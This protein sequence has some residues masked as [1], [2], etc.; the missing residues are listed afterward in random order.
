MI[1]KTKY[2]TEINTDEIGEGFG[3]F[4]K[5]MRENIDKEWGMDKQREFTKT[6]KYKV[7]LSATATVYTTEYIEAENKQ[8]AT[9]IA[10]KEAKN[11]NWIILDEATDLD[12][13]D[14][15][16]CKEMK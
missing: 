4:G 16:E 5:Y 15:N 2:G 3:A 8:A 7:E 1:L 14:V 6:K 9:E 11:Y 12:D 10:L 13:I